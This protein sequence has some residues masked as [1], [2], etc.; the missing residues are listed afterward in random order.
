MH[1][2][3][4]SKCDMPMMK[5]NDSVDCVFCPKKVKQEISE[6]IKEVAKS[7]TT[8][9]KK[10]QDSKKEAAAMNTEASDKPSEVPKPAHKVMSILVYGSL[11]SY[12]V[13]PHY[14]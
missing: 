4:C 3:L 9:A 10:K 1:D 11:F 6:L 5:N 12:E 14:H 2:Q 13:N 8:H 7:D